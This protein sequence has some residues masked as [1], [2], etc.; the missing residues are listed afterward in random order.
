MEVIGERARQLPAPQHVVW[1]DLV[2]P[3]TGGPRSWLLLLDDEVEPRILAADRP[4]RVVWSSLWPNRPDDEV[5]LSLALAGGGTLLRFR[6]QTPDGL[7]DASRTGHLRRRLNQLL[8]GD[9]RAAY[10]Q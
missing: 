8:F 6:L 1:D 4:D 9:L 5:H 7:P 10:G 3:R 2:H